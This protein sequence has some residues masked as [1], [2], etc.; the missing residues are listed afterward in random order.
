MNER[1]IAKQFARQ[2][3][4]L[5]RVAIAVG[6]DLY[7]GYRGSVKD[8][9]ALALAGLESNYACSVWLPV[10]PLNPGKD[11]VVTMDGSTYAVAAIAETVAYRRLD[12]KK[13]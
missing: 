8:S 5:P 1:I 2:I 9:S 7:T 12:L 6:S 11:A 4:S 10:S 13:L 3:A